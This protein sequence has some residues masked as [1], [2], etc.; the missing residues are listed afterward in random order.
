MASVVA[1]V[2]AMLP[3]NTACLLTAC[4]AAAFLLLAEMNALWSPD[5]ID[6]SEGWKKFVRREDLLAEGSGFLVGGAL[7]IKARVKVLN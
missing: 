5:D 4:M 7:R 1:A 6:C 3:G 2:L